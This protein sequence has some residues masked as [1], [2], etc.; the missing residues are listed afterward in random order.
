MGRTWGRVSCLAGQKVL[1]LITE[2]TDPKNA[3]SLYLQGSLNF[4]EKQFKV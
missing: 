4:H 2:E 3:I 1:G